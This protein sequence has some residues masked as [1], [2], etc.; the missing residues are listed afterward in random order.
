MMRRSRGGWSGTISYLS[1]ALRRSDEELVA[2]FATIG[3]VAPAT[4]GEKAPIVE[5]GPFAY[6]LNKDG[7]GGIWINAREARRLRQEQTALAA[8]DGAPASAAGAEGAP[9]ADI[10]AQAPSAEAPDGF[11]PG[12]T[13]PDDAATPT[14]APAAAL[15]SAAAE[16]AATASADVIAAAQQAIPLPAEQPDASPVQDSSASIESL[17]S[18]AAS[19]L[20]PSEEAGARSIEA[21]EA[22]EEPVQRL[23]PPPS[24]LPLAGMRLLLKELRPGSFSGELCFLAEKLSKNAEECLEI[25]LSTGLKAP[26]KPREKT[27]FVE[28]AGEV[29]WLNR[30][31]KGE[32]WLNAKA[33]KYSRKE[34]EAE[35]PAES[36]TAEAPAEGEAA[37]DDKKPRRAPRTRKKPASE[38]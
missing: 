20:P 2:A 38:E 11:I 13:H 26:D 6:W 15:E 36:E 1:R 30:N 16:A 23:S 31:A 12:Q 14:H 9:A 8:A 3:L 17:V 10:S 28:H 29:F 37:S 35:E 18:Q 34:D 21:T 19:S 22:S 7:R 25:L 32:L 24:T 4:Q 27:V 33:S 5:C